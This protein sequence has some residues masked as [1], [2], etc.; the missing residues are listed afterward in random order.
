MSR[1]QHARQTPQA[2]PHGARGALIDVQRDILRDVWTYLV[3]NCGG[4]KGIHEEF[5]LHQ[6]AHKLMFPRAGK[7]E[8][9]SPSCYRDFAHDPKLRPWSDAEKQII[10][11]VLTS[12]P[13]WDPNALTF[14]MKRPIEEFA[15]QIGCSRSRITAAI[16]YHRNRSPFPVLQI[17]NTPAFTRNGQRYK[18]AL[19]FALVRDP[20]AFAEARDKSPK[21]AARRSAED[22]RRSALHYDLVQLQAAL[23]RGEITDAEYQKQKRGIERQIRWGTKANPGA[24]AVVDAALVVSG[25]VGAEPVQP[26]LSPMHVAA[27][28]SPAGG[29]P[30]KGKALREAFDRVCAVYPKSRALEADGR[31][32]AWERWEA[33]GVPVTAELVAVIVGNLEARKRTPK[34]HGGGWAD[35]Q[36]VYVP[37]LYTYL[38]DQL[39]TVAVGTVRPASTGQEYI[40][41]GSPEWVALHGGPVV[42]SGEPPEPAA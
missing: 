12:N 21:L 38:R 7:H 24:L 34:A 26:A 42:S 27:V 1:V 22:K 25:P 41:V 19:T 16:D 5:P 14:T 3:M 31:R 32:R 2:K 10:F 9:K 15:Q 23:A 17:G 13:E 4:G 11:C 28:P 40:S 36:P 33:L 35:V 29:P 37:D 18:G 6:F 8:S 39:W 30:L 20:L